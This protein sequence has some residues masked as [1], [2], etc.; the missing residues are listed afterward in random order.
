[1]PL[2]RIREPGRVLKLLLVI[3][4]L[5]VVALTLDQLRLFGTP[6]LDDIILLETHFYYALLGLLLPFTFLLFRS[7]S[8]YELFTLDIFLAAAAFVCCG[9]LFAHS[10]LILD[11]GWEFMAPERAIQV[12]LLLWLLALEGIRRA[13]GTVLFVLVA[14]FSI[15]PLFADQMPEMISEI[16]RAHV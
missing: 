13:G 5:A 12:S 1:M 4:T 2:D 3:S 7:N 6:L 9:W 14:L 8:R 15:Y 16:G 11:E 10:E